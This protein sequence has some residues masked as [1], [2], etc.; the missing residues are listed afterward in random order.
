MTSLASFQHTYELVNCVHSFGSLVLGHNVK[1]L[2]DLERTYETVQ[3]VDSASDEIAVNE[4]L[5]ATLEKRTNQVHN[6]HILYCRLS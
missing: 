3:D 4:Q 2:I 1:P 5:V 6:R